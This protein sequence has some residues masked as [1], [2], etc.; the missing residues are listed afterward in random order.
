MPIRGHKP[1]GR[2]PKGSTHASHPEGGFSILIHHMLPRTVFFLISGEHFFSGWEASER[3]QQL[4]TFWLEFLS[5]WREL[6]LAGVARQEISTGWARWKNCSPVCAI[7]HSFI[8]LFFFFF[9]LPHISRRAMITS[10]FSG[11]TLWLI[12][13][14]SALE[15]KAAAAD[16]SFYLFMCSNVIRINKILEA[17]FFMYQV[18]F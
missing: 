7:N 6:A 5:V 10:P 11:F 2:R 16:V 9:F 14:H 1:R 13:G 18:F 8:I 17:A 12:S 15:Y 4:R 3:R